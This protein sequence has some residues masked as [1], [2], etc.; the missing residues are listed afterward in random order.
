[1]P[2]PEGPPQPRRHRWGVYTLGFL[3]LAFAMVVVSST[4]GH[5]T[6]LTL[7]GL[8]VGLAGAAWCTIKGLRGLA[9][10]HL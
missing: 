7:L 1:M 5:Y 10:F 9:D 6:V 8:L 2:K 3:I 4:Q